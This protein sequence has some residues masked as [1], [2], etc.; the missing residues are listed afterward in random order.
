MAV[1]FILHVSWLC[2]EVNNAKCNIINCHLH[3]NGLKFE[4]LY[5]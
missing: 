4:K 5:S 2:Y 3:N 1:N